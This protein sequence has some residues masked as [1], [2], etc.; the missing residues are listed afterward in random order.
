MVDARSLYGNRMGVEGQFFFNILWETFTSS[1]MGSFRQAMSLQLGYE[2]PAAPVYDSDIHQR[3]ANLVQWCDDL[4][5][6]HNA[7]SSDDLESLIL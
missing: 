1:L 3:R 6:G 5:L 4:L 7:Q 2:A